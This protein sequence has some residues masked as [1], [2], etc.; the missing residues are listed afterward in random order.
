MNILV[1]E[2]LAVPDATTMFGVWMKDKR[3]VRRLVLRR[4]CAALD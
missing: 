4:D 3:I 2:S 1:P